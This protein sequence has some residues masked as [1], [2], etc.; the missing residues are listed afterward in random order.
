MG[1]FESRPIHVPTPA[2]YEHPP[3]PEW[4]GPSDDLLPGVVPDNVILFRTERAA[5]TLSHFDVYPTGVEFALDVRLRQGDDSSERWD[6][7][8]ERQHRPGRDPA[9]LPDDLLRLG[10]VFADGSTWTNISASYPRDGG[11]PTP[12][13]VTSRGGQGGQDRW[14]MRQWLWPLPPD[15]PLTFI[16]EWPKYD[17]PECR[18]EIDASAL[19]RAAEDAIRLWD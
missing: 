18:A 19:R 17:I 13:V 14:S 16:A 11:P 6:V 9:V 7:P 8:W 10:I 1:F 2:E 15:G 3:Q 12:P 5:L 4:I